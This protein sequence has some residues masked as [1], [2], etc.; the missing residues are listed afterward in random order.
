MLEDSKVILSGRNT[1][2]KR[3]KTKKVSQGL[4]YWPWSPQLTP[5]SIEMG[6]T[7]DVYQASLEDSRNRVNTG[8]NIRS[9]DTKSIGS[10]LMSF[11]M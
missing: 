4:E 7:T 2:I 9:K 11:L 3:N 8:L 6:N 1:K 5:K 10:K